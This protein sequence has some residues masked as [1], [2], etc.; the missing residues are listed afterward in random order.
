M[1]KDLRN[2]PRRN[3]KKTAKCA[4]KTQTKDPLE[5]IHSKLATSAHDAEAVD[6]P[7]AKP[8]DA[9][10]TVVVSSDATK[11]PSPPAAG[12]DNITAGDGNGRAGSD[13]SV[14][15]RTAE[16][17][18][19]LLSRRD[20]A[21]DIPRSRSASVK[22]D[23]AEM[24]RGN[25]DSRTSATDGAPEPAGSTPTNAVPGPTVAAS[26][27]K[28]RAVPSTIVQAGL[29]PRRSPRKTGAPSSSAAELG[30]RS[31]H[32]GFVP[33]STLFPPVAQTRA[34]ETA[35]VKDST[36]AGA[37]ESSDAGDARTQHPAS[38]TVEKTPDINL[39]T[40]NLPVNLGVPYSPNKK[41]A[42]KTVNVIPDST[43]R[44]TAS[45]Q[46]VA[47]DDTDMFVQL[48][49]LEAAKQFINN[50]VE[51][52]ERHPMAFTPPAVV[53]GLIAA[54]MVN[55]LTLCLLLSLSREER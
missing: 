5:R 41:I 17:V 35:T 31:D 30:I 51:P 6:P 10:L 47:A 14:S 44:H 12:V 9:P 54:R 42:K 36:A 50:P 19:T 40:S 3:V 25:E 48:S 33:A 4:A 29:P 18:P 11:S 2:Q 53:L 46:V 45:P 22:V 23:A 38:H 39:H 52:Q 20:A 26:A 16:V 1:L 21:V 55:Q 13:E 7:V 27:P 49:P 32:S 24:N 43:P 34:G 8:A 15:A 37:K 28:T